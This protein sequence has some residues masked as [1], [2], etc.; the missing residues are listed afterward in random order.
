MAASA[1]QPRRGIGVSAGIAIGPVVQVA[2]A[3]TPPDDEPP[4]TNV[5][6]ENRRVRAALEAVAQGFEARE[7]GASDHAIEILRAGAMIARDPGL[8]D[9]IEA[10]LAQGAGPTHAVSSAVA[11]YAAMLESL[12]GYMAERVTDLLD[13][14]D[15]AIARL[16]NLPEPGVPAF[17]VPSILVARDL[18]P[19]DTATL[20]PSTCLGI[21]T[22]AGGP[23]SHTAILAAQLAIPAAVQVVDAMR[24][25]SG[26]V[27]ALDGGSGEV[28]PEPTEQQ[29]HDLQARRA[30]REAALTKG[31]GPGATADG[32]PVALL[33]NIGTLD[34]AR[35]AADQDVEG[36]GLFRTEF[37]YLDRD[38]MPSLEEQAATY[39]AV[40]ELFG[41]RRIVVRTLDAGA[42]KPLPFAHLG[43]E[44][45]P[46]LGRRGL[47]LGRARTEI[48]DAQLGALA[49]AHQATGAD[50]RVMA[51]M[52]A[53][54]EEATW[55]ADKVRA[56]GLPKAGI[57]IE[58]PAAAIRSAQVLAGVDFASLGTN[59]LAQYTMAADRTLGELA[60][61]LDPW[62]PAVLDLIAAACA[63]GQATDTPVGVC[64]ESAGDPAL[65]VVLVGLGVASLSMAP[66]K[67]AAV[68]TSLAAHTE[69][70]CQHLAE[71]ARAAFS[72]ED[73]R[74]AVLA[75]ADPVLADLR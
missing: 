65:A 56:A 13:V 64:G 38:T 30:R 32:H 34:D 51:P 37:L 22:E 69:A 14:R 58:I 66:T 59:D 46:A 10:E 70:Q 23:T 26:T 12:G 42:D 18:A 72:A 54:A 7:S 45:N 40:F 71:L 4:T 43:D 41:D 60:S 6:E 53:T 48:M 62:E 28:T 55:F 16:L 67:V 36:V 35:A 9:A 49:L 11:G 21:I 1:A 19:A 44:E 52:V 15:R 8:A 29:V 33:A 20:D 75:A 5:D 47:R 73:A 2:R 74:E 61:L 63:G 25:A 17:P 50:L 39:R 57:M 27:V 24:L 68:R 31:T 3:A